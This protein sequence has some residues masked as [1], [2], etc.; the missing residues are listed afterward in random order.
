MAYTV[1]FLK[2]FTK[3]L[4]LNSA[5]AYITEKIEAERKR[6]NEL[7]R[8][9]EVKLTSREGGLGGESVVKGNQGTLKAEEPAS[10]PL[11]IISEISD[12]WDD[13]GLFLGKITDLVED[14]NVI[15][16]ECPG[17][18]KIVIVRTMSRSML[19]RIMLD[20]NEIEHILHSFSRESRIPRIGGV[21][22]AIVSNLIITAI[23][24][25]FAGPR[26]IITKIHPQR[27]EFL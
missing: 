22:K 17:P 7:K 15:S 25:E 18:N 12:K 26:F 11:K 6:R 3:E 8:E 16:V 4:I 2:E 9:I 10:R 14:R 21:F 13:E 27:S 23:D 24:S 19:T 5:P 1:L 20:S